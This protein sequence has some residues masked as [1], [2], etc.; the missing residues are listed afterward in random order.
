MYKA[1]AE[2]LYKQIKYNR[3]VFDE[4]K[5]CIMI[6]SIMSNPDKGTMSAFCVDAR[7][8]S[9]TFYK[10]LKENEIFLECYGLGQLMARENWEAMGREIMNETLMPGSISYKFDYWRQIGWSRFGI[11]KNSRIRLDLDPDATPNHHYKQLIAQASQGDFTAGEIKQ[12][13]EAINV[14]LNT[15]QVFLLQKEIDQLKADLAT[16]NENTN[17]GNNTFSDKGIA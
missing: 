10:W 2:E 8:S 17:N 5:H 14:G 9:K 12:L 11:G 16:M 4:N 3:P 7:I 15:H 13:M 1:D 6:L